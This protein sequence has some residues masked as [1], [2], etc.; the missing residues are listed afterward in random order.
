MNGDSSSTDGPPVTLIN[1]F[2]VPAEHVDA[3]VANWR[4][5]AELLSAKPG[6]LGTRLYR[7][8][9]PG[10]RFQLV[11][12]AS[13]ESREAFRAATANPDLYRIVAEYG[14]A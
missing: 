1:V 5:R 6:F 12:V 14:V 3:F 9:S 2:E 7:A 13:W 8:L 10:A 4:Y 11:N